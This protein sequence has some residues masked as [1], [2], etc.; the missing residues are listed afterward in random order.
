M[1][2]RFLWFTLF[3]S[4]LITPASA[5]RYTFNFGAGPGFPVSQASTFANTSYNI[6]AGA[7]RNLS[8]HLK[9]DGEFM[10]Q[11]LPLKSSVADQ[12][13]VSQ[14][15]GRLY[16]FTGN[17][18]WGI[19]LG[20]KVGA[21]AIGGGG[22]YRRTL[23]AQQTVFKAGE[24]CEPGWVWFAIECT[25]GV[26]P[27]DVTVGSRSANAGGFNIGGGLTYR[28]GKSPANLYAEVRYH[29]AFTADV[30]TTVLPLT[31]GVRW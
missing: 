21:Y 7:G 26:F 28:L 13:G 25:N 16:A 9:M 6:V 27:T 11:G 19:P 10:F 23:E 20:S 29:K 18:L 17:I 31:F 2:N 4:C 22:F 14:V 5:Q 1:P 8:A 24:V 12:L 3:V 15:K 30:D